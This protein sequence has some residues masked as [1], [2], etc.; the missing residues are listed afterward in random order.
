MEKNI[1][2]FHAM[3]LS[4]GC[5][6]LN[7]RKSRAISFFLSS[8]CVALAAIRSWFMG[9]DSRSSNFCANPSSFMRKSRMAT[10]IASDRDG[11]SPKSCNTCNAFTC[12]SDKL[13][14][15]IFVELHLISINA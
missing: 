14:V 13:M 5:S 11:Y 8:D 7:F 3:V 6:S 10:R 12:G 9:W 15:M 1:G 2:R 4:S